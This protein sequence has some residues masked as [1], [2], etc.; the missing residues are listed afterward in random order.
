MVDKENS[1]ASDTEATLYEIRDMLPD[2][3]KSVS[4]ILNEN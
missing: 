2:L 4:N 3:Q 1:T